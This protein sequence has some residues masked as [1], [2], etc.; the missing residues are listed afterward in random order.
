ML[1]KTAV[2]P[3]MMP[4]VWCRP[5]SS[6][7]HQHHAGAIC[8]ADFGGDEPGGGQ[9]LFGEGGLKAPRVGARPVCEFG[10]HSIP[11]GESSPILPPKLAQRSK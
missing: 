2:L 5:A 10:S 1:G 6:A 8:K 4:G 11:S 7:A 3:A 9:S